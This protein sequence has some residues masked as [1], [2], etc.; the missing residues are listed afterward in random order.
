MLTIGQ[1]FG[2]TANEERMKRFARL[3]PLER[4]HAAWSDGSIVVGAGAFDFNLSV[5]AADLPTVGVSLV[6]VTP[7]HRR[8]GL[9]RALMRVQLDAAHERRELLAALWSSEETV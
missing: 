8:R 7:T 3:L 2:M 4:M 5:P 6:V 9:M 1:Y